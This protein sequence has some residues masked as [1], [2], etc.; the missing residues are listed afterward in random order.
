VTTPAAAT[1]PLAHVLP[2]SAAISEAGRLALG[3]CDVRDLADQFG[4]P[5]YVYDVR[6]IEQQ[7][8]AYLGAFRDAYP[9]SAVQYASKAYLSRP[10]ARLIAAQGLGFDAVT[11][12][13]IEVL[14]AAEVDMAGVTFHGNNKTAEELRV[15]LEA[16]VGRIVIDAVTEIPLLEGIAAAAGVTQPVLLRVSPGID[17]HTHEKTTTGIVDSKFGLPVETGA[18][19]EAVQAILAAE[20]LDFRGLHMHLGSPIFELEPYDAGIEVT[21]GFAQHIRDELGAEI[22]EFSPGGGFAVAYGAQEPP[23][24]TAYAAT[25]AA[26]VERECDARG[27]ARPRL[28]VEPGRSIVGRAGVAIYT[29]GARKEI[30]GVR[31]YVSVDG[32][33]ADNIRPAMYDAAYTPLAAERPLAE[34][35][36]TVT[37]AGKYCESGDLLV[38]DARLPRLDEGE[39]LAIP[40]AGAYQLAMESNYNLAYR[41]AV[42]LVEDGEA[43]LIRRRETA[44]DLMHLDVD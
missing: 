28:T 18:A 33:M 42:V 44:E 17:A 6:T 24:P 26:A 5:L 21:L 40:A 16:G 31:T 4:T 41:A 36:E 2:F 20:H 19:F 23:A 10:F 30:P 7:C 32:G 37:I 9:D 39:L 43:R 22:A 14:R 38:R 1:L 12:G 27:L 35:Q 13:E 29:V 8:A 3:G 15:A 11:A 34:A 25:I